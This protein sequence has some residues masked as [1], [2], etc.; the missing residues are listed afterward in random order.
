[1]SG[2]CTIITYENQKPLSYFPI[3]NLYFGITTAEK[4]IEPLYTRYHQA[5]PIRKPYL[6][7]VY[8]SV[9][10]EKCSSTHVSVSSAEFNCSHRETCPRPGH[11]NTV[12]I[13]HCAK[14]LLQRCHTIGSLV[15]FLHHSF[16]HRR[17]FVYWGLP[18]FLDA[19]RAIRAGYMTSTRVNVPSGVEKIAKL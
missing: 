17:N 3:C 9:L 1:M 4:E 18:P 14:N 6:P 11:L 15:L 12:G 10:C 8:F 7:F 13:I 5:N 16:L 19:P 2:T